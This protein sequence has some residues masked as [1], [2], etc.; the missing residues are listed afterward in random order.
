MND[1]VYA[2]GF[3]ADCAGW[4]NLTNVG[5]TTMAKL[6]IGCGYVGFRVAR[7]WQARGDQVFAL[8]RK[9][10]RVAEFERV[11][12]VPVL[13]DVA[14]PLTL[15]PLPHLDTVLFAVGFDRSAP[16]S[17][18]DIYVAGLGRALA[19]LPANVGRLIYISS[20]GVYGQSGGAWVDEDSVCQPQRVGG[21]AV[22]AAEQRLARHALGA[23]SVVLRAAGIYGPGRIP[24]L[25]DVKQGKPVAADGDAFLNLVHV[26]DLVEA[27]LAAER[28]EKLP[29]RYVVGDGVPVRR[30][31]FYGEVARQLG[32][33]PPR[34]V[35]AEP[36]SASALR[37]T[38]SKRVR[39][40]RML[41]ELMP[42][43]RYPSYREGLANIISA[44]DV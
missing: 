29:A 13:G 41:A 17:I 4:V 38:S 40:T 21:K 28:L 10:A 22:L 25:N 42:A 44:G 15:P 27:V 1:T 3:P 35:A 31:D 6:I 12:I 11:G 9:P 18:E 39:N 26:D 19:V 23:R 34:F 36:H 8:T 16:H 43:L 5:V 33:P 32:A 30:A 2:Q 24:K 20:T 7:R 37:E 14:N